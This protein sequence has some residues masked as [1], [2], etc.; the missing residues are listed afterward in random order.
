MLP[1][2]LLGMLASPAFND[3]SDELHGCG[4]INLSV[5]VPRR[6]DRPLPPDRARKILERANPGC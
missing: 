6:I 4:N 3:G 5:R 2:P 1:Q